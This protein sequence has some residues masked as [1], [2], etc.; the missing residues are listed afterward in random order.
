MGPAIMVSSSPPPFFVSTFD[1]KDSSGD[2]YRYGNVTKCR[3]RHPVLAMP[4][5]ST[6]SYSPP[7]PGPRDNVR[8][9]FQ[10]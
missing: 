6:K 1:G 3:N 2:G 8:V 7:Y 10:P 5:A 4:H 9:S